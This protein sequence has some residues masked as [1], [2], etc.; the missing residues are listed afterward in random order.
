MIL[1]LHRERSQPWGTLGRL[2]IDGEPECWT[3]EDIVRPGKKILHETAIPAGRYRVVINHSPR[4]GKMLPQ[5]LDVPDFVGIRI[6]AGNH[7]NPDSSGCI[8]VGLGRSADGVT[9]S[10]DAMDRLQPQIAAALAK[11]EQVWIEV[12]NHA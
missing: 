11:S 3:C 4:F 2:S 5:L 12:M 9:R 6:H 10:R 7:A 8:L 1:T